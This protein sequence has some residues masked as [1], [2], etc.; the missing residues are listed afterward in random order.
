MRV[1]ADVPPPAGSILLV[2]VGGTALSERATPLD[3]AELVDLAGSLARTVAGIHQ[4]GVVHRDINPANI[5]VS[6]Q[7]DAPC[8]ID[9]QLATMSAPLEPGFAHQSGIVGALPYLATGADRPDRS[10]GRPAGRPVRA[11]GDPGRAGHRGPA[12]ATRWDARPP[13]ETSCSPPRHDRLAW[14]VSL[15]SVL[16]GRNRESTVDVGSA[17]RCCFRASSAHEHPMTGEAP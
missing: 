16:A 7:E 2:D 9:F 5:V 15:S 12:T 11:R 4:R 8:L 3:A 6:G 17:R 13:A 10:P 14:D 1:A